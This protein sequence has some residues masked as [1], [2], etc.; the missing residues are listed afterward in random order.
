M[1]KL[2]FLL[3]VVLVPVLMMAQ[4]MDS[5]TIYMENFDG[6]EH[7]FTTT[8]V[9]SHGGAVGDWRVVGQGISYENWNNV[10]LFNLALYK[11]P[12]KSYRSPIYADQQGGESRAT[13][14]A[15]PLTSPGLDVRKVYFDFDHIC[16][17]NKLDQAVI[18]Y[19]VA[20]GVDEEG[21]LSWTNWKPLNFSSAQS[22]FY[23]G[24]ARGTN[25]IIGGAFNDESYSNWQSN[26]MSAVPQN[27]WW[28][29]EMFD[30]T[31]FIAQE[32]NA[33]HIRFRFTTNKF[34]TPS[35]GTE[36]CSGW[37]IDNIQVRLS[38]CEL[39]K[40]AITM[41]PPYYYN[42][43]NTFVNN[44]GPYP[45][46]AQLY[47]NDTIDVN[48]VLFWYSINSGD[49]VHVSN[50]GAFL[51][52][53]LNANGHTIMAQWTLPTICYYDTIHYH[54][55]LEDTHGSYTQFD[56]FLV[57][58][59]DYQNIHYNDV[60]LDTLNSMPHCLITNQPQPITVYF[61]NRSDANNSPQA[62]SMI[63]GVFG[64][65]VR[66]ANGELFHTGTFTWEGDICFD[67]PSSLSLG[68]F[69]PRQG[70]NYVTVYVI[71]RN[72]APDG[73]H[74][75]DTLEI[76]PYAC[77]S[78]MR[79]DYTIGG[80]NP[81]FAN[82]EAAKTSLEF[83]GLG[84]PV[85][86][87]L[88]PGTYSG[89]DFTENYE[90]QSAVNT[91][92]FQGD[93]VNTV[94]LTNTNT[95]AGA[96]VFGAVTLVNV[97][98]Y[99]FKNLTIQGKQ[100]AISRGVVVRGNGSTNIL[101]EGCKI[102]A[103]NTN[104]DANSS[105]AISRTTASPNG[106]T[107]YP[108]TI[109]FRNCTILGGNFGIHYVGSATRKN[110]LTI[111]GCDITSCYRGIY[112]NY[113]TGNITGNHIKQVTS[114]NPQNFTGLHINY[115]NGGYVSGNTV[116]SVLRLEYG[117][118]VSNA[119][120]ADYHISGNHLK[121]GNGKNGLYI[122]N[123]STTNALTGYVYNNEIILYPITGNNSYAM[124]INNSNNLQVINNSLL[125]KSGAPY[126][127]T[128]ALYISNNN[129]TYI[130]NN[131]LMNEVVNN[132]NTDY[133]LYL[134]GSSTVHGSYL[135]LYSLSGVCGYK[136][137]PRNNV[138]ELLVAVE[139]QLTDVLFMQVP[140]ED[141]TQS[142]LPTSFNGLECWRNEHVLTDIRNMNRSE[143]TYMGA[144]ADMIPNIDIA[145]TALVSPSIGECPQLSYDI[146]VEITNK[147]AQTVDFSSNSAVVR[148]IST[149]LNLN[150][151]I[152]VNNGSVTALN[153]MERT[154]MQNVNIPVNQPVDFKIIITT[155]GDNN[156][157][158]DTLTQTFVL[159][160]IVPDYEEDFSNGTQQ[161]WTIRQIAGAGNWT[162][163][164]GEGVNPTIMPVY[165]IGRMFFNSKNFATGT[166]SRAVLPVVVLTGSTN[167]ILEL[168]FAHDNAN[169]SN[170]K[171][172]EMT[173]KIST[174]GG[175]TYTDL[176]PQGQTTAPI[177][178]YKQTAT[179]PTWQL[180]TFD[181][182]N[183]INSNCV[184]IAFDAT[185]KGG[186]NLNI[187]R[188]R[189]RNLHNNDVAV[190]KIYGAGETP[191]E[192]SMSDVISAT[193]K[194]EGAL[195]QNNVK[196]YLNV[197]G[198]AEQWHDSVTVASLPYQGE[199]LVTF[200]DHQYNVA[201]VKDVEVR[202]AND[203]F[204][205][206]NAM[207]WRMVTTP[208]VTT[209]ADTSTDI[210]LVGDYNNIIR[211]CVRYKINEEL[212]VQAV[213][214]Y[215]DQT[216][217][218]DPENGFRAFVADASGTI[219]ATSQLMDFSNLQQGQWNIIPIH[220][221][222]LTNTTGEFYVGLEMLSHGNYL[223]AQVETP[224]RDST[225]Y[226]LQNGTYVPQLTG[227][228]M[229]G[230]VVDTPYIND[231]ALLDLLHPVTAC[232]LGHEHLTVRLTNNGTTDIVPPI[233]LH[234]TINNGETVSENFTDTLR[235]HETTQFT[236]NSIYDFTNNQIDIDDNY[237]IKVW[238]TK[239]AQDRLTYNDT[240][241]VT[242]VSR[243][244]SNTPIAPDT[245]IVN[246][247]TPT[248]LTAQLPASIPQ[249]VLGWFTNT[250]YESWHLLGYSPT[251]TTP[252]IYFDTTYYVNANPGTLNDTIVGT[253]TGTGAEP[254]T[255]NKGASRGR[256]LYLEEQI[257]THGTISSYAFSVKTPASANAADGIPLKI[258]MKC[259]PDNTLASSV[260]W[261][262]ELI[263]ATLVVDERVY[264]DHAG[265][266]YLNLLTPFEFNSG[267][268]EVYIE[269]NCADYCTGTVNNSNNC[270]T[271]VFYLTNASSGTCYKESGN[272]LA[273][274]TGNQSA[275]KFI[276]SRFV[277]ANLECGSA[278]VPIYLHVP[279]IPDY[280]VETQELLY[281]TTSCALYDEHIQVQVK[282]MLNTPIPANKVVIHAWFNNQEVT[283]TVSEPFASEETKIVEFTTPFD[284][285]APNANITFNYTIYTT[286]N[287]ETVVYTGN[288]TISGQFISKHT[289]YMPDS[290]VY[291]GNYTQ[292]YSILEAADRPSN[293]SKYWFYATLENAINE[294][295]N[296][297]GSAT[298]PTSPYTTPALY[299]TAVYWM[300]GLT[301]Q[302]DNCKTK[303]IKVI[304]NVFRPQYDLSTDELIYPISYQCAPSLN[305]ILR[306][307][308]TNQD[309]TSNSAIPAGTFN[310]NANFT[311]SATVN[312]TSL[313]SE[314]IASL[315]QDT[316][317]FSN[318]LNL[319][320]TTQN[321]IYQYLVYTTPADAN[322]PVYT[323]NDTISGSMY[324]PAS[325]LAPEALTYPVPYGGTVNVTPGASP[326]NY[327]YFYENETD[328]TAFAEGSGFTTEPI[329][330]P[331]TYYYS[332]RIESDGFNAPVI[333][334]TGS[335]HTDV[336]FTLTKGHSYAKMLYNKTDMG[337]AEGRIDSIYFQVHT[338]DTNNIAFPVR[339][340]LKDTTDV[341][342]IAT[343]ANK[344]INWEN[345]IANATLVFDG[346][347]AFNHQGWVGFA[348]EGG[349]DFNGEGLIVYAEHNCG[350]AA[351]ADVFG[352][353]PVPKFSNSSTSGKRA[354]IYSNNSPIQ[355]AKSF[356]GKDKRINTKFKM[357][358]T[359][360]SPKSTITINTQVPQ[361]DV[362]VVEIS[363]PVAQ[364]NNYTDH[365]TV[366]VT[367]QNFGTSAASNIP[368]SYQLA[369]NTPVTQNYEGSIAAGATATM[370]FNTN[371][372]LTSVYYTTPFRAYTGLATDTYHSNDTATIF[373]SVEI[374]GPS[375]PLS[376]RT[377]AHITNVTMGSLNNGT[378][379]PYTNHPTAPGNGMYSDF[380]QSVE[381]VV[382][383]LGQEYTLSVT[384]A[385][386]GTQTKTVYKRVFIDY[387]R[388][389]EF[390]PA[391]EEVWPSDLVIPAGDSNAVTTHFV[392]VAQNAQLGLTRMRV[393]CSTVPLVTTG[394][395]KNCP[396][397]FYK[398]DGETE[399]YAVLL[400]AP[401]P[402]DL[403]IP[404]IQH[405][406]GDVCLD[407]NANIR[408]TIRNYGTETQ[409][410]STDNP[411]TVT[412]TVTGAVAGTYTKT[413]TEG[414]LAPSG[415]MPVKIPNVNLSGVGSYQVSF[416]LT[417][418]NDQYLT[419]NT[420]S[421]QAVVSDNT[422]QQ[423]P[424]VDP[425]TPQGTD[426]ANPQ[427][428]E[429]W[430]P[431][432]D[433]NPNYV[434][435]EVVGAT[436][437]AN[438]A[439]SGGPAHDHTYAGTALQNSGG[440]FSVFG[441]NTTQAQA[442]SR[443]TTLTSRCI[444]MHYND[445]YPVELYFYKYIAG[446]TDATFDMEIQAGSGSFYDSV[447]T[448]TRADGHQMG[449]DDDWDQHLVVMLPID[450][451]ARLRFKVTGHYKKTDP[452]IDDIN[453]V[454]GRPDLAIS[455]IVY[456]D[457]NAACLQVNSEISPVVVIYNNGNSAVQEFDVEFRVGIGNE[458]SVVTDHLVQYL[459]PGDSI[460]YTCSQGFIVPDM[461]QGLWEV[462][463]TVII[464]NDK[465][466]FNSVKTVQ[467]CTNVGLTDYEGEE[468]VYLGQ[469]EPNP[470]VTS[471]RIPYSVP[472]P[473]KVTLEVSNAL[474]QVLFTTTQEAAQGLNY[475]E[476][477]TSDLAA[478]LYYYT[479]H[480]NNVILTKKMI[481]EK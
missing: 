35:A 46:K 86:F 392:N 360:E 176:I 14:A 99:V 352:I 412:A 142:L 207:H 153:K 402:I 174:D 434:W 347:M 43:S 442:Q 161:I 446:P 376:S 339:F 228:F 436:A 343:T 441:V 280:D 55:Y 109:T 333:S 238:A 283:H 334:G 70:Y 213:K 236:F 28:H 331:T 235:S 444:N 244:K 480:Y 168:W 458:L 232:D 390:D 159:E 158:N 278:K 53:V 371:A 12:V 134:N 162:F 69:A 424:Y 63:S 8:T 192:Y 250:G 123:S 167:P 77:D 271:P 342:A 183:Y 290:I 211:P 388:D 137:V 389:G 266:F 255:L 456:P 202:A 15:I 292:N 481:V 60:Q 362:G 431:E 368:V 18:T 265:W 66:D 365:E 105:S 152:N 277:V 449:N 258:W 450:E 178:R 273:N 476:V 356:S 286:L 25:T 285:S 125:V 405:P 240:L 111:E 126:S 22:G 90:G 282:N 209:I 322:M 264:F 5:L 143:V 447:T 401:M 100:N 288:D 410:F 135:T 13:S 108:D 245:V 113:Y 87:H 94:I 163:Q 212:A 160:A 433:G 106:G 136:T 58:H 173:V 180:Y 83:C 234:Y 465:N 203:D 409:T 214:Y 224:L 419:N 438:N 201:E 340:W 252:L 139:Q 354:Y 76:S 26:S 225:F 222:A 50:N 93:D 251:Y 344:S 7:T 319:G 367:L 380:T 403:G 107:N 37:Y 423:L 473:G 118:Y 179:V 31:S 95:D 128:A 89:F 150:Q 276:N 396:T 474:G 101:F 64:I 73:F 248:T 461:G 355:G 261:N 463:A 295:G 477:K 48:K 462:R 361:H 51:S 19:Q 384:H 199:T 422:V 408:V 437:N 38:N 219:L 98:D 303:P 407:T 294:T 47:D 257:G 469:N 34:S 141:N 233:Q 385:F 332:G 378:G 120:T 3:M 32:T 140:M 440:Y 23:Y 154:L 382:M 296:V 131:I 445:I 130:Y 182:H 468:D 217:I 56:T 353:N 205:A 328:E 324:I 429:G 298:N 348:V 254:M 175:E 49:T 393:I 479:I 349:Y 239:L 346:E 129:N 82:L 169:S 253:G 314:S 208:N 430:L 65:E 2:L 375:R 115:L 373:L 190:T 243:G 325:P 308:V 84:G 267:N 262:D 321:R 166:I 364:N 189:V 399:D 54:I 204:N 415:E 62:N 227:R 10:P 27:S 470:A 274:L 451:V 155:T 383:I 72:G 116:D 17:V 156:H 335:D 425:F 104:T 67:V 289:A 6:S 52:N 194:N 471:T 374:V 467:P 237:A 45:I 459:A 269:T 406:V 260:N 57:A 246:Y 460:T 398:G 147:G 302:S 426:P 127:N 466:F 418:D 448:L 313:I 268:L 310:L 181:L 299:D 404:S 454:V 188:I 184:Y 79:G 293:I 359:C 117:I 1:K 172:D 457:P 304:I 270:G 287:N 443:I 44:V 24:D 16:K 318:G 29:H 36:V 96:N 11:S 195:N 40:P 439:V 350:D 478:G 453:M 92:T 186:N 413:I 226:Y 300:K 164:N 88:R 149:A 41:Q 372:D 103:N 357:N 387:N 306:V 435:R 30:M 281:P 366:T 400:S 196:V 75:N 317:D 215:Y 272:T 381:P 231:V 379:D 416:Q 247:H 316:V 170:S 39:I 71:S 80:T 291:T 279:D 370:T 33:T 275:S 223:C 74:N 216:Y 297:N 414:T 68:T 369:D 241:A 259:T 432:Y 323:L 185:A 187:D 391:T 110:H 320:S 358:Y 133:P 85:T 112:T 417:Y 394:S 177:K 326:L 102:T 132:D 307:S 452:S 145:L 61:K 256:I 151:T 311:G 114:T 472:E 220:N 338:P 329:Y 428:A 315:V 78:L 386:T 309:T 146:V 97:R 305:P 397:G 124:Q 81:D 475:F 427:P 197:T 191:T 210:M 9:G 21:N 411:F 157:V 351:C 337:G 20:T 242:V 138:E 148:L 171:N 363:A 206:N 420:R 119:A 312:G 330:G 121:V 42:M 345:E 395:N 230:A 193:V 144:Y 263:G 341:Q 421:C 165:G 377:G 249:G 284:F 221:F 464:E 91:I 327:Y 200:P 59:H 218:A 122:T 336:M 4:P 455:R 198:A 301:T 229:I